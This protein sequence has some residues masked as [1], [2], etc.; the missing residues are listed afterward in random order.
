MLFR[1]A[2]RMLI[3]WRLSEAGTALTETVILFPVL[4]SLMMGCFDLGQ[5]IL[6]NQKTIGASQ[7]MADLIAR[8]RVVTTALIDDIVNAGE[9]A[10]EPYN[11]QGLGY[12]IASV[13][14]DA[15]GDPEVLWR[16]TQNMPPNDAAVDSSEGL[17]AEGEGVVVVTTTYTYRPYFT[18][19]V[20]DEINMNEV[21]F[22]RGRRSATVTCA[23]CP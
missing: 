17:G 22:L 23:D 8:N 3:R 5:G 14:F 4:I 12:D 21:A 7:I 16:V 6:V 2:K 19:F 13:R 15:D 9:L 1:H 18:H 20:V 10:L 11:P